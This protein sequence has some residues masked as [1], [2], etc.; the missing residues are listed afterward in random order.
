MTTIEGQVAVCNPVV[1]KPKNKEVKMNVRISQKMWLSIGVTLGVLA[2][3]WIVSTAVAQGPDGDSPLGPAGGPSLTDTFT[4]QGRLENDGQPANGNYDFTV[5]IWDGDDPW[6]SYV[7]PCDNH[8]SL[9]D[10]S[11]FAVEDGVFT[12]HLICDW[13][14]DVFT[15]D[16]R[17]I[18]VYVREAGSGEPYTT[19]PRQPITAV[20]YA[21]SLRPGAVISGTAWGHDF[22]DALVNIHNDATWY[23]ALLVHSSTASAVNGWS[24]GGMAVVGSTDDGYAVAGWDYGTAEARGY[25]GF[26]HSNNGVG[27][28]GR[29]FA[30]SYYSNMYA[31]GV[32]G[33]SYYGTGVYGKTECT[34]WPCYGGVFEGDDGLSARGTGT[35]GYGGL[36]TS[37]DYRGMYAR[38]AGGWYA[39]YFDGWIRADGYDTL[40]ASRTVV[41]NG[42]DGTL[43]P[44]D[45][46][47]I[48]G[49]VES[50]SGEPL[51]AVRRADA[52]NSAAVVGVVVQA[53]RVEMV[54]IEGVESLDVQPV[55]GSIPPG[56]Y[57]AIVT[58]GLVTGVKVDAPPGSL[59]IGDWLGV[60]TAPG[61]DGMAA[62]APRGSATML[63]KVAGP[64][65]AETGTVPVFVTL[66]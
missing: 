66:R 56:G 44:G 25:G 53:M 39:G 22:G 4:Y 6:G 28:Y 58:S 29:S 27:L 37:D 12:F 40:L 61:S 65:D 1:Q 48:A 46:V 10:L 47:A 20:P 24:P 3:V 57:L 7:A 45:V 38:G 36:F 11:N 59:E 8:A 31:P 26:F 13:N 21:W 51:L 35:N 14:S 23:P 32:Y 55:E 30:Q 33:H 60:S 9:D 54:E 50:P 34:G 64:V 18:Q 2:L 52:S 41:V 63:G 15:G 17:W 43:E 49:V 5:E 16:P 19:L 42:G 62:V